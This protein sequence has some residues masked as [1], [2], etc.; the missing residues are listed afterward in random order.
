LG[1]AALIVTVFAGNPGARFLSASARAFHDECGIG[2][3]AVCERRIEDAAA[4]RSLEGD[5]E[6]WNFLEA[7]YRHDRSGAALYSTVSELFAAKPNDEAELVHAVGTR[8]AEC[9]AALPGATLYAPAGIGRHIDH[10]VVRLA[11]ET[12]AAR[13]TDGS[14]ILYED[15]PYAIMGRSLCQITHPLELDLRYATPC[16]WERKI[17]AIA[18]Y[19]SQVRLLWGSARNMRRDLT[20]HALAVGSGSF[21]ERTWIIGDDE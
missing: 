17:A 6:H 5:F 14:F 20:E 18:L 7:Y 4:V 3:D 13:E 19:S 10:L 9:V 1:R 2:D 21:A 15:L 12:Y 11:A 16:R 8:L